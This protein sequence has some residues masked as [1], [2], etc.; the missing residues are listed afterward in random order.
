MGIFDRARVTSRKAAEQGTA[1][2]YRSVYDAEGVAI[3]CCV[4][5]SATDATSMGTQAVA[6][7]GRLLIHADTLDDAQL[8][9]GTVVC[10]KNN[11]NYYDISSIYHNKTTGSIFATLRAKK[12]HVPIPEPEPEI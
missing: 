11:S 5:D 4:F 6:R 8:D 3:R 10:L 12:P 7:Q 1:I 2:L 9:L